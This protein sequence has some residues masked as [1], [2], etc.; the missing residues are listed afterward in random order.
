MKKKW[1]NGN[2]G[3]FNWARNRTGEYV[4]EEIQK[5]FQFESRQNELRTPNY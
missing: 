4:P 5:N 3:P 2:Y 1:A